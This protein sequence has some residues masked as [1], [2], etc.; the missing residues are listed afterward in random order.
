[1][2]KKKVKLLLV[3]NMYPSKKYPHYG[4]FVRNTEMILKE[5]DE[6]KVTRVSIPKIDS[7]PLKMMYYLVFYIKMI[8]LGIFGGFDVI[9]GHFISHIARP[10]MIIKKLRR[11]I[12]IVINVHGND[13]VPDCSKDEKWI[14]I[15]RKS[16]GII[17][18]IIVPSTYFRDIMINEYHVA[19]TSITVFPSGGV[20]TSVFF[21]VERDKVLKKYNLDSSY[22][23]IGYI[24]RIEL[25]KGWDTFLKAAKELVNDEKIKFIVVGDGAESNKYDLLV[26]EYQIED[27]IIKRKLLSQD[28]I[29][30]IFNILDV[31]VFPTRRKSES[32]GLVGLEAMACGS[33]VL[34]SNLYG[35]STYIKDTENGFMFDCNSH[36]DLAD[37]ITRILSLNSNE[38]KQ[39]SDKAVLTAYEYSESNISEKLINVFEDMVYKKGV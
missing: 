10:L 36:C 35:P 5:M 38:R 33:I 3:S 12:R 39:I 2:A 17:D 24:S 22:K 11:H 34:A 8:F 19:E 20:N 26:K 4:V 23:Y 6:I 32:L 28:E 37:K 29:A 31:F 16:M 30:E 18:N 14:P 15:V 1:M 9:Y 25:N 21:P 13:V 27:R 7:K